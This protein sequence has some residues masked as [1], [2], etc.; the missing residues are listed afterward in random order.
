ML[1]VFD[2]VVLL[3]NFYDVE[4]HPVEISEFKDKLIILIR[5][6]ILLVF[7]F[8]E[9]F[10]AFVPVQNSEISPVFTVIFKLLVLLGLKFEEEFTFDTQMHHLLVKCIFA[11]NIYFVFKH[12]NFDL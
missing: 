9:Y 7:T 10:L 5:V 12:S 3:V 11:S 1:Q 2:F 8:L 6:L 4:G